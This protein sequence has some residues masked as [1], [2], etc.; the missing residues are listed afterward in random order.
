MRIV[1]DD[2]EFR[3]VR[4][5]GEMDY[6]ARYTAESDGVEE[7]R[8]MVVE[9]SPQKET[10]ISNFIMNIVRPKVEAHENGN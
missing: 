7:P 2:W 6:V 4:I 1:K 9:F 10:H 3:V 5:G 8:V